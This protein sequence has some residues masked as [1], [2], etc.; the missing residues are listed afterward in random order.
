M[1]RRTIFNLENAFKKFI[2]GGG[3]SN[4]KRKY[5]NN[6]YSTSAIYNNCGGKRYCNIEL[7]LKERKIK[8]PKIGWIDIRGYRNLKEIKGKIINVTISMKLMGNIM[9]R[10]CL[11]KV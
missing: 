3:Y 7:D 4:Y 10:F 8:L 1:I 9:F 2:S 11:M 6:Y 5:F